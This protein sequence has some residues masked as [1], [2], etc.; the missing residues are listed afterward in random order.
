MCHAP[1]VTCLITVPS[2]RETSPLGFGSARPG[3]PS[4]TLDSNNMIHIIENCSRQ[5]TFVRLPG[6]GWRT[7][8]RCF[9]ASGTRRAAKTRVRGSVRSARRNARRQ[10]RCLTV[11]RGRRI[12]KSR[13]RRKLRSDYMKPHET[14]KTVLRIHPGGAPEVFW[15]PDQLMCRF[16]LFGT[17][18]FERCRQRRTRRGGNNGPRRRY[19]RRGLSAFAGRNM[20]VAATR[21]QSLDSQ[22]SQKVKEL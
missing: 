18:G 22:F 5:F 19:Q 13:S 20:S 11:A 1:T 14:K 9:E 15:P 12:R 2:L 8:G 10:G 21:R 6:A 16:Q 4:D 3:P 7:K 17:S